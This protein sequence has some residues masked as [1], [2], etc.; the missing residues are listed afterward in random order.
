[1]IHWTWRLLRR[2]WRQQL[3]MLALATVAMA[4]QSCYTM[5]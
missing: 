4:A 1:V 3:L 5:V 2:E